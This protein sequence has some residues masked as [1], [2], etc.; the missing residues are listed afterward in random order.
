MDQ[1]LVMILL[2]E[3]QRLLGRWGPQGLHLKVSDIYR[4][5]P[6]M[7]ELATQLGS[8]Y[9]YK[10]WSQTQGSLF[11]AV[12]MEKLVIATLLSIIIAVAAF[13]IVSSLV[14]MVADKRGDIAVLRTLGLTAR[15]VMVVFVV[16]GS[17]VGFAG[18]LIGA[19]LGS[20]R[21]EEHTSELQSR[22]Q[23]VCR[24]LLE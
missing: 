17:A 1:T 13:N 23:L 9:E 18:T 6:V 19:V 4:A 14:L 16:Q 3:A 20:F 10:D 5:G 2:D 7:A 12:Q 11:Q 15:Q 24:L 8:D 21:S 22:G